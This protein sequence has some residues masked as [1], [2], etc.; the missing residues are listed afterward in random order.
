MS[1]AKQRYPRALACRV[2]RELCAALEPVTCR[3]IVAGSLRRRKPDVGDVEI[4]FIPRRGPAARPS[5]FFARPNVDLAAEL[6][7]RLLQTGCLAQRLSVRGLPAWGPSNKLAVH[8]ATG[9]PVDFFTATE[10]NWFN[11]LVCRTGSAE[12]NRR[13]AMAAQAHGIKWNPYGAGFEI[14]NGLASRVHRVTSEQ[15][16]FARV[17]LPYLEPWQR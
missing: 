6:L 7:D 17:K 11:Y 16:V 14:P 2:A 5:D 12:T 8:V 3:L 15:E 9:M 1:E 10:E 13:I 4:L